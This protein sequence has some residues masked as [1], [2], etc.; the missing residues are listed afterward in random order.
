MAYKIHYMRKQID[1]P[2][3]LIE[4]LKKVAKDDHR[5]VK[6]WM[7]HVIIKILLEGVKKH[8]TNH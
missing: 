6:A 4:T 1:L 3:N 8:E 7:E 2:D 5:S